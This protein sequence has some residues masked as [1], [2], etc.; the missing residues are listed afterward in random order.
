MQVQI[1]RNCGE[2]YELPG[3]TISVPVADVS[4]DMF[5]YDVAEDGSKSVAAINA[6]SGKRVGP[7]TLGAEFEPAQP[8]DIVQLYA[9][10]LGLTNPPFAAGQL[11][12]NDASGARPAPPVTVI[13]DG[14]N[15]E[16]QYA[17][18][19]PGFAGLYQINVVIPFTPNIGEVPITIVSSGGGPA[20]TTPSN[21]FIAV[22]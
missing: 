21:G 7:A 22:Q 6:T 4:P 11:P 9:T 2:Y 1:I 3:N 18:T 5:A 12:P 8:G 19:A 13:V 15:A 14:L 10:G 17:G 16:V 20:A